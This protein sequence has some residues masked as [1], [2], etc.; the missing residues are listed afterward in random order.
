MAA[1]S[2]VELAFRVAKRELKVR[3]QSTGGGNSETLVRRN[4]LLHQ[5]QRFRSILL[6]AE[7]FSLLKP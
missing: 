1:G 2:V 4:M 5:P 3:K 7:S 6:A